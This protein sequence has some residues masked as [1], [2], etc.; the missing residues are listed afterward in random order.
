MKTTKLS[1]LQKGILKAALSMYWHRAYG[2]KDFLSTETI[3]E[4]CFKI[5]PLSKFRNRLKYKNPE[6]YQQRRKIHNR[7]DAAISRS[8]SRLEARGLIEK[9]KSGC[10]LTS[11]GS[12]VAKSLL[13]ANLTGPNRQEEEKMKARGV[14]ARIAKE[15]SWQ[16][17]LQSIKG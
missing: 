3:G 6:E 12:E 11:R 1:K 17:F 14:Q 2:E 13:P 4:I 9:V 5:P 8:L 15:K 7:V 10:R 16:V